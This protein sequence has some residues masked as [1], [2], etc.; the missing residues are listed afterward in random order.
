[1][2]VGVFFPGFLG[3]PFGFAQKG[4]QTEWR[5]RFK[6]WLVPLGGGQSPFLCKASPSQQGLFWGA[7]GGAPQKSPSRFPHAD[8]MQFARKAGSLRATSEWRRSWHSDR[9]RCFGGFVPITAA[10]DRLFWRAPKKSPPFLA[11]QKSQKSVQKLV[12]QPACLGLRDG[13][14]VD[15]VGGSDQNRREPFRS[16]PATLPA[17][18]QK[19]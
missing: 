12:R 14:G 15:L 18:S 9:R 16:T 3:P 19:K 10:T 2:G 11:P 6:T 13:R 1:V 7:P 4:G 8:C 5:C 17:R